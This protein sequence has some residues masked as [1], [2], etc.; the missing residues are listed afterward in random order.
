M[1][2][3]WYVATEAPFAEPIDEAHLTWCEGPF[4]T[5]DEALADQAKYYSPEPPFARYCRE[6]GW[7]ADED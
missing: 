3:W 2:S 5:E 7:T 4:A 6:A 1:D